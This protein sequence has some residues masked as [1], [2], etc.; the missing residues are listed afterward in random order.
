MSGDFNPEA[1]EV[2]DFNSPGFQIH[3]NLKVFQIANHAKICTIFYREGGEV[4][5]TTD[6]PGNAGLV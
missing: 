5:V 4:S 2:K 3:V 1:M 6:S